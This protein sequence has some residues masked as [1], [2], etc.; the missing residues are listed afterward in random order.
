ML[1]ARDNASLLAWGQQFL[2]GIR[3]SRQRPGMTAAV[4]AIGEAVASWAAVMGRAGG[5]VPP[6]WPLPGICGVTRYDLWWIASASSR[7]SQLS[8][9]RL[10]DVS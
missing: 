7:E 1:P 9:V 4:T 8:T 3:R 2:A 10:L 6:G 5:F